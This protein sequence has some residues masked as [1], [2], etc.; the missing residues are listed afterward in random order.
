VTLKTGG[1]GSFG[2]S[3]IMDA[4]LNRYLCSE[5]EQKRETCEKEAV[6]GV[7][8]RYILKVCVCLS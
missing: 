1:F 5:D 2:P 6:F 7:F 3:W 4:T 8:H